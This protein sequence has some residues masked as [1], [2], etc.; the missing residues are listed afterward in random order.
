MGNQKPI[1][2]PHRDSYETSFMY[3]FMNQ[4]LGDASPEL[5]NQLWHWSVNE[6]ENFWGQFADFSNIIFKE[7][8]N[9]IYSEGEHFIKAHWFKGH[10]LSFAENILEGPDHRIA[11]IFKSELGD[12]HEISM[13]ELRSRVKALAVFYRKRGA[14]PGDRIAGYLPNLPETIIAMLAANTIGCIWTACSPDFGAQGVIDRIGQV[15]P[16]ILIATDSYTFRGKIY[17]RSQELK[18]IIDSIP[19]IECLIYVDYMSEK[20]FSHQLD[21][22]NFTAITN[23]ASNIEYQHFDFDYPLYILYSSGTTG[24][25]KAIIHGQ[26]GT[27]L[28][29]KKEHLLHTNIQ[30]SDRVFY[31]ST[32]S[33]MMWHWLISSLASKATVMLWEGSPSYPNAD[34]LW[35]FAEEEKIN[36]FGTSAVYINALNN[37]KMTPRLTHD[38]SSINA[39]LSTGS[40]LSQENFKYVYDDIKRDVQL[41]SIAGGTD[42]ISCFAL[43]NPMLPIYSGEI[44]CLGLGMD[45][46]IMSNEQKT[47]ANTKGELICKSPFPSRPI[48]FWND[49]GDKLYLASYFS[50]ANNIWYHGDFAQITL[51][52]GLVIHGRSDTTLNKSGIRI[53]TAEIYRVIDSIPELIDSVAIMLNIKGKESIILFVIL[54]SGKIL[55]EELKSKITLSLKT[56]ASPHHAPDHIFNVSDIP[57]TANGKT[58]ESAVKDLMTLGRTDNLTSISNAHV[59]KEYLSIRD[60]L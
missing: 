57:K 39:I 29:H 56:Q 45:V 20:R 15:A 9:N 10:Q 43:G 18:T 51:N 49:P 36:V 19:S 50:Q 35:S 2:T 8:T 23:E 59:M 31:Y 55:D 1:W 47:D 40:P 53:G 25:P 54:E 37:L 42:L 14:V 13:L 52:D 24:L 12:R 3:S 5:Y 41:S 16:K 46:S 6:K 21:Q 11:I 27:L 34:S 26:G 4:T 60:H 38:L 32:C 22:F 7:K 48:G 44:Q 33:W 58:M 17:D 28:Q 30:P